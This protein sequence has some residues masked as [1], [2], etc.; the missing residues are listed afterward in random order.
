M[1]G[2]GSGIAPLR[3]FWQHRK[4]QREMEENRNVEWGS[5]N[6]YAGCRKFKEDNIYQEEKQQMLND[7]TLDH[8][9]LALSREPRMKKVFI[10]E[11]PIFN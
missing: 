6:L 1:V 2:P 11:V 3:G 8:S 5:M 9:Y 4:M 10:K 7:G